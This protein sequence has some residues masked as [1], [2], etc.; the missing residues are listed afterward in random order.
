MA[1]SRRA[2]KRT[3]RKAAAT[4]T[5]EAPS[6]CTTEQLCTYM[7]KLT[8]PGNDPNPIKKR[9]WVTKPS[10]PHWFRDFYD[11]YADLY[12]A[13]VQLESW[14]LCSTPAQKP[15][16]IIATKCSTGSNPPQK[17]GSPPPPPFP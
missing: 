10:D 2:V 17:S 8:V 11:A 6:G 1:K 16:P 14:V 15:Q 9:P 7:Q 3:T 5:K 12:E 4:G 13:V